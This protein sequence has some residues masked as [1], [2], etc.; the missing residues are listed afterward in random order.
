[1]QVVFIIDAPQNKRRS[2]YSELNAIAA[3]IIGDFEELLLSVKSYVRERY[4][5]STARR[6]RSS[7]WLTSPTIWKHAA[8][9]AR[10]RPQPSNLF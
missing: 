2:L 7:I 8:S 9:T 5:L 6:W 1:M 10:P 3:A 4:F